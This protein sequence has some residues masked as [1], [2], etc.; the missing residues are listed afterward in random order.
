MP[1]YENFFRF[2]PLGP[3]GFVIIWLAGSRLGFDLSNQYKRRPK[4]GMR[5][6][7]PQAT[8]GGLQGSRWVPGL[9]VLPVELLHEFSGAAVVDV[10]ERQQKGGRAGVQ[11]SALQ[12]Q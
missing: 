6:L 10:P 5:V 7:F 9:D 11:Q 8:R 12:T 1:E 4:I 2:M 3:S